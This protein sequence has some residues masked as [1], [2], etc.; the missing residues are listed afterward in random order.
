MIFELEQVF[1]N[2]GFSLPVDY[3][4]D[5]SDVELNCIKPFTSPVS[6][7]GKICNDAGVV[8][9]KVTVSFTLNLVCDRCAA[10]YVRK[11][12]TPVEHVLVTEL[13]NED[14]DELI[15]LDSLSFELDTLVTDDIFLELPSKFLCRD[16]CSGI[17]SMCGQNLNDSQCSC[18]KPVDPRL[19]ALKQLLDN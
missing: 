12:S 9:V 18:K 5:L 11:F 10:D 4:I 3:S 1:N 16:D 14:N 19:E 2:V 8:S 6:V 7:R 13:N 17:C 15:L